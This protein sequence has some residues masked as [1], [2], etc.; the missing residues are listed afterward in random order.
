MCV[1]VRHCVEDNVDGERIGGLFGEML[2][3]IMV[4]AFPFPAVAVVGVVRGEYHDSALIIEDGAVMSYSAALLPNR[5]MRIKL[6]TTAVFHIR[7]HVLGFDVKN[8]V[9]Q[10]VVERQLDE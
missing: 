5:V 3:V 8:A 2:E 7:N 1:S 6:L 4:G 9:I 10:W